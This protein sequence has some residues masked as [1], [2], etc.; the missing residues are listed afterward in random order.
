MVKRIALALGLGVFLMA[1]TAA[2]AG[3]AAD[4]TCKDK[5]A[6]ETGKKA[7]GKLKAF[8]KNQK[9]TNTAKLASDLSKAQSK[10]TK[11]FTKAEFS[12]SGASKNCDT[13]EDADDIEAKVDAFVEDVT[14]ELGFGSPSGAFVGGTNG[15]LD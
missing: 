8:G 10:F 3:V 9:A 14:D 13:I 12:G 2:Y 5:K 6:K 11:G 15:S 4:A 1:G 7:L